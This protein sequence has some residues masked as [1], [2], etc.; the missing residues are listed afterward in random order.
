MLLDGAS[1]LFCLV[2]DIGSV[3]AG[4]ADNGV[5]NGL[6]FVIS[7]ISSIAKIL[8]FILNIVSSV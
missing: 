6:S 7:I 3:L 1:E 2:F 4:L 5:T 8:S